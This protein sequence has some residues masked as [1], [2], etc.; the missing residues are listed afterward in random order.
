MENLAPGPAASAE[1]VS[2]V[3]SV[4]VI[5]LLDKAST[6]KYK[7]DKVKRW[8]YKPRKIADI[9]TIVIHQM[10]FVR[11]QSS[12]RWHR[13]TAHRLILPNGTIAKTHPL[14]CRLVCSN[15]LDRSP[16]NAVGIEVAG[17]FEGHPGKGDWWKPE[18]FGKSTLSDDQRMGLRASIQAIVR[19]VEREDGRIEMLAPHRVCGRDSKGRPNRPLCPGWEIWRECEVIAKEMGLRTPGDEETWG[20]MPIPDSWRGELA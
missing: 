3:S 17:N 5:D 11:S 14:W 18:T 20:G 2:P 7:N 12:R 15:S 13:V 9:K 16:H 6:V 1:I 4:P 10:G 19:E 8:R